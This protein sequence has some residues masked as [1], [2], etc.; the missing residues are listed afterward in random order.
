MAITPLRIIER[1]T[2][3][4][5]TNATPIDQIY[6]LYDHPSWAD[7]LKA[8]VPISSS[9][10][11]VL[12]GGALISS[13]G[14]TS[15]GW[16]GD[17]SI[18]WT[19]TPGNISVLSNVLAALINSNYQIQITVA[20]RTAGSFVVGFGG[21][22]SIAL[23]S[24]AYYTILAT[25][26]GSLTVTPTT[27]FNG[28]IIIAIKKVVWEITAQ[29][30]LSLLGVADV[31]QGSQIAGFV[32]AVGGSGLIADT[33]KTRLAT[34]IEPQTIVLSA[35]SDV[36]GKITG[37]TKPVG[38]TLAA[39]ATNLIITHNLTGKQLAGIIVKETDGTIKRVCVP[40]EEAYTGMTENGLV[41][42]IE[43][44]NPT[45]LALTLILMFA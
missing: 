17:S 28:T 37:A 44:I 45:A 32:A 24:S 16:T 14:W 22:I 43:G 3:N 29:Q 11:D 31:V 23:N 35:A 8:L 34:I 30:I 9:S 39:D 7:P 6:T 21:D 27:D 38:W 2:Y 4:P 25:T 13:S 20:G 10:S 18:G 12:L 15:S 42:T 36:S 40:F 33:E 1:A 19:H 41:I 26:N 5:E